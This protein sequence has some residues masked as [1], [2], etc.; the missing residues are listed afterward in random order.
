MVVLG[1]VPVLLV[2]ADL[3]SHHLG[4]ARVFDVPPLLG[5]FFCMLVFVVLLADQLVSGGGCAFFVRSGLLLARR[6]LLRLCCVWAPGVAKN[7]SAMALQVG[8]LVF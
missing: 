5:F 7:D 2:G 1:F 8:P 3:L 6:K 4:L